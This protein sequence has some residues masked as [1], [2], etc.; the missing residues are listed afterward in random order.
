MSEDII[1]RIRE[2]EQK[3]KE[4]QEKI[5]YVQT[6]LRLIQEEHPELTHSELLQLPDYRR[7]WLS[8]I[9]I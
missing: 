6:I 4:Q 8:L 2:L 7:S 9:H 5:D 1:R 3:I